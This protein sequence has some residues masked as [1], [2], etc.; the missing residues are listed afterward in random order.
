MRSCGTNWASRER[1]PEPVVSDARTNGQGR[2]QGKAVSARPKNPTPRAK[3]TYPG[4]AILRML[5]RQWACTVE[6]SC[7]RG[8]TGWRPTF[9]STCSVDSSSAARRHSTRPGQ[10]ATWRPVGVVVRQRPRCWPLEHA[11]LHGWNQQRSER[12]VWF[13]SSGTRAV[14][15]DPAG[16]R[17]SGIGSSAAPQW[18]HRPSACAR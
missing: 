7:A 6:V 5:C 3:H 8:C 4:S 14:N 2:A 9:P 11:V 16:L 10:S 17:L 12:I 13:Y 1:A 18:W 15:G